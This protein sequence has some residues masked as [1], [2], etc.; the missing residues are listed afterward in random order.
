MTIAQAREVLSQINS[1]KDPIFL[2]LKKDSRKGV[3][4]LLKKWE[5][6]KEKALQLIQHRHQML[7]H[8]N[9]LKEEGYHF[10]AGIDEVGRGPLAGP[11]VAAAVILPPDIPALQIDDSKKLS[12][13]M[14]NELYEV[15]MEKAVVGIGEVDN[16]IID[17]INIY[18]ATRKAM[19]EAVEALDPAPD[20]LLIDAM[21]IAMDIKQISL[22]KGDAQSYSIA[23]ASIV[24]K[25]YRDRLMEKYAEK[26][27]NYQFENNAGYGTKAHLE[28]LE[29]YGITPIHRRSFEPIKSKLKI[30]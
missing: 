9:Q 7:L 28:G 26:F 27:P 23:A 30:K 20:A 5:A 4:I 29:D 24:A 2:D 15:I 13:K 14:R 1:E 25:V 22:I 18:Q 16:T 11:V 21:Q 3:Q 12:L 19:K 6:K 17:E 8:E 10:I